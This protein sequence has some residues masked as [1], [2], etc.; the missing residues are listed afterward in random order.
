MQVRG[1]PWVS[2]CV[3]GGIGCCLPQAVPS[4][5]GESPVSAVHLPVGTL[6]LWVHTPPCLAFYVSLGTR[7]Q[8][9]MLT[10]KHFL[11]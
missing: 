6:G 10:G 5:P 4:A 2:V 1:Q 7:T 11:Y 8:V 9:L 3:A